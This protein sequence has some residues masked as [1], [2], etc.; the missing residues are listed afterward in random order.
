MSSST[1]SRRRWPSP[2]IP[3]SW[4]TSTSAAFASCCIGTIYLIQPLTK[5]RH[6]IH[7]PLP[8]IRR[9]RIPTC[10]TTGSAKGKGGFR[11]GAPW[12]RAGSGFR[13]ARAGCARA[14]TT[15]E[16]P[17]CRSRVGTDLRVPTAATSLQTTTR[18]AVNTAARIC[19]ANARPAAAHVAAVAA[20]TAGTTAANVTKATVPPACVLCA[21]CDES[22]CRRLSHRRPL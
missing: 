15:R 10:G 8:R 21:G 14:P 7:T 4:R 13:P 3:W 17:M 20:R 22:C 9:R 19:A 12:R 5:F 1:C 2:P 18:R 6:S 16:A 11:F